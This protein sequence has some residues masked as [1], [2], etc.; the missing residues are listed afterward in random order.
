MKAVAARSTCALILGG[1]FAKA[2]VVVVD[3]AAAAMILGSISIK[4]FSLLQQNVLSSF[5][6]SKGSIEAV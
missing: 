6:P 2:K 4:A 3:G 1:A 5:D